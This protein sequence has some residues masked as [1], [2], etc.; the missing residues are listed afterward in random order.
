MLNKKLVDS[1]NAQINKELESSYIYV[2]ISN[3]YEEAGLSGFAAWFTIQAGEELEHAQKFIDYLHNQ[4]EKVELKAV[5]ASDV[6]FKDTREP[7]VLQ[8]DHEKY[9]TASINDIYT[10]ALA[11]KDYRTTVFLDWFIT[12]QQEEERHSDDLII[13]YDLEAIDNKGLY[14]LDRELK[15]ARK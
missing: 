15:T 3:Y 9:I 5:K 8:L 7:L 6:V 10:E 1:I 14:L 2:H 11:L 12:E 4:N 13:K